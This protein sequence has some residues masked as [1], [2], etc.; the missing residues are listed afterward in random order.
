[1]FRNIF[2]Y[3]N[4]KLFIIDL[5]MKKCFR[6]IFYETFMYFQR[7]V[8][9]LKIKHLLT[10]LLTFKHLEYQEGTSNSIFNISMLSNLAGVQDISC[11][12]LFGRDISQCNITT[13]QYILGYF[14]VLFPVWPVSL[15][16]L[17]TSEFIVL[18]SDWL[19]KKYKQVNTRK[20][21]PVN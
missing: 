11:L 14:T 3:L 13:M 2:F 10:L 19:Y 6:F 18:R 15:K 7:Y 16:K 12:E 4:I 9:I 17:V 20:T 1:M 5:F 8:L 21:L